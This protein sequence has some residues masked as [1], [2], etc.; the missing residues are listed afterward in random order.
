MEQ[1]NHPQEAQPKDTA[2]SLRPNFDFLQ[3]DPAEVRSH[4]AEF[5]EPTEPL[6]HKDLLAEL[7]NGLEPVDFGGV[8]KSDTVT[9]QHYL[10]ITV[11]QL[12]QQART[13]GWE[14]S[15]NNGKLYLFNGA[16]WKPLETKQLEFFLGEA[17]ERLGVNYFKARDYRFKEKLVKQFESAAV[18]SS[19]EPSPELVLFNLKN[20]TFEVNAATGEKKLRGFSASDFLTYQLPFEYSPEAEAPL[21]QAYLDRVLPE[22]ELQKVLAEYLGWVFVRH[23]SGKL[24]LEKV[25]VLY[26]SGANGKSVF[27]E[28]TQALFGKDSYST[29]SLESLT[30]NKGY[31]RASLADKLVN[32]ASEI[33]TKLEAAM[34][35][36]LISGEPIEARL[37]YGSPLVISNYAKFIFNCNELPREVEHSPAFWRRWLIVPFRVTIPRE[38]RDPEL[39]KKIISSE[40]AGVFNW[41]LAGLE[42]L[43]VQE[44]FSNCEACTEAVEQ[45]RKDSDSVSQFLEDEGWE[46]STNEL[47]TL[48]ELYGRYTAYCAENGYHRVNNKH[49]KKRLEG[50]E[51]QTTRRA[52]GWCVFIQRRT[53]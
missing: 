50:V 25:L 20:G 12:L 38:E 44:Q 46:R 32:Y 30:D 23:S 27:F 51:V 49:F 33:S 10:V 3:F 35:K 45:F 37:P 34:F 15:S 4:L 28:I 14:L 6:Q 18:L 42:R 53:V 36:Q 1:T 52:E 2:E 19:P 17:A 7:L 22:P 5:T 13:A 26:G 40:L 41:A 43:L 39:H 29:F 9:E 21:F 11:E 24:K 48:K 16:Y 8:A 31:H 47:Q